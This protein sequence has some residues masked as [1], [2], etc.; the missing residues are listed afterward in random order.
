MKLKLSIEAWLVLLIVLIGAVL[1]FY[2][3]N[4]WSLSNDELSAMARL[5]FN[6]FS[7]MVEKGVKL[8]DMH[9]LG[10]QGFLFYWTHLLGTSVTVFR[11]PFVLMGCVSTWIFYLIGARWFNKT[12]A[13]FATVYFAGLEF[14]ILYSQLARPYSP[15]LLFS[16]ITVYAWTKIIFP[17]Q[18]KLDFKSKWQWY[19]LFALSATACMY[20]HYFAFMF[21][22]IVGIAGLFFIQRSQLIPYIS[23]GLLMFLLYL[24]NLPVF[25]YQFGIGGLGGPEGWLGPPSS[26][27]IL[28]YIQYCLNDSLLLLILSAGILLLSI[29]RYRKYVGF[30]PFHKLA[31]SFFL[32]PALIA[33]YYSIFKN[34]VFQ[35]SILIFSFPYLLLLIFSFIPAM[36]WKLRTTLQLFALLSTVIYST[37]VEQKFY[38]QQHF[39]VFK[40]VAEKVALYD[41]KYGS[42]KMEK[43]VNVINEFYIDYYMKLNPYPIPFSQYICNNAERYAVLNKIASNA[44]LTKPYFL[45]AWSNIYHAPET[46]Q[47]LR[48]YYPYIA[49]YDSFFNSG[50]IVYAKEKVSNSSVKD[51][52]NV[53]HEESHGFESMQWKNDSA[54][55]STSDAHTGSKSSSMDSLTEYG[56]TYE[57]FD[58]V[59]KGNTVEISTWVKAKELPIKDAASI[60]LVIELDGVNKVWRSVN[61]ADYVKI[62]NQWQ[63]VFLAYT[64]NEEVGTKNRLLVYPW[65]PGKTN[66]LLDDFKIVVRK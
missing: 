39:G 4:Q 42:D 21:V 40:D 48:Q 29:I 12:A 50:V 28:D 61:L 27:A 51:F 66:F 43:T 24:P 25:L 58:L 54:R 34:P 35:C 10:V 59:S 65:N 49:E 16:L 63:Q 5:N 37:V 53:L 41:Q 9:P 3:F 33:Y 2:N 19:L 18:P 22:G 15:G 52:R 60:V 57:A 14:P 44:V 26:S 64:I 6:S 46:D 55:M 13:L 31:I 11:L 47:I 1:R 38:T 8:N 62:A 45:H 23:A 17:E 32:I 30:T 36:E 7:E 20:T 56:A